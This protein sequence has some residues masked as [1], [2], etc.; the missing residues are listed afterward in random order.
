[1]QSLIANLVKNE[2]TLDEKVKAELEKKFEALDLDYILANP[3]AELSGFALKIMEEVFIK[4]SKH[5]I[6]GGVQFSDAVEKMKKPL[7]IVENA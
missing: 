4:Y 7:E 6:L 3:K 5:Y 2:L 1:M